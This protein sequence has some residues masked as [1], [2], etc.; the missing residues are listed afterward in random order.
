MLSYL[1]WS[2]RS[3]RSCLIQSCRIHHGKVQTNRKPQERQ[4]EEHCKDMED[5][6]QDEGPGPDPLRH[7]AWDS[8]QATTPGGGL[9]CDRMCT[10]LLLTLRVSLTLFV[11]VVQITTNVDS[12]SFPLV[13]CIA[14]SCT[15]YYLWAWQQQMIRECP[16]SDISDYCYKLYELKWLHNTVIGSVRPYAAGKSLYWHITF[17]QHVSCTIFKARF[18]ELLLT[19]WTF[20]ELPVIV[21][22]AVC[23]CSCVTGC[24]LS[25]VLSLFLPKRDVDLTEMTWL[26]KDHN[27][28]V[29]CR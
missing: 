28:T 15:N 26:N 7:E 2:L 25:C 1:N 12:S 9:R 24:V 8:S 16:T 3:D 13:I 11:S 20:L 4:E 27:K 18:K 29:C 19:F 5:E 23:I 6:A 14:N 10:A 22:D 21:S 17:K